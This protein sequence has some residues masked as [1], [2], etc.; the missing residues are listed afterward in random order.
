[1]QKLEE[2][3]GLDWGKQAPPVV[4]ED[5]EELRRDKYRL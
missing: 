4:D 1:V 5:E 2:D 3:D